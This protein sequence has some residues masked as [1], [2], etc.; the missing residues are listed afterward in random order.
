VREL[1]GSKK[2]VGGGEKECGV[3]GIE[4]DEGE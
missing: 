4:N 2:W 1:E 3:P